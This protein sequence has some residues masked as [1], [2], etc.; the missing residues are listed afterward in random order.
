MTTKRITKLL[1]AR[2]GVRVDIGCGDR[3]NGPDWIGIDKRAMPGVDI[4]HDLWTF[5]WPLPD[6]CA[7]DVGMSHYFEHVPPWLT[8]DTMAE[9]HRILKPGGRLFVSGPYGMGI[10]YQQDPTHCRPIIA[11]TFYYWDNRTELWKVYQPPVLHVLEFTRVPAYLDADFNA[12]LQKCVG[13]GCVLC[14]KS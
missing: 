10:R 8:L 1:Q 12:V 2:T 3:K 7:S 5:P 14:P 4:V 11:G 13:K 9:V 6:G